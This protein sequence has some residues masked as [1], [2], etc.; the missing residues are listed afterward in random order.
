MLVQNYSLVHNAVLAPTLTNQVL[1]G[2]NHFN[3][4][5]SD[6]NGSFNPVALGFI[7]ALTVSPTAPSPAIRFTVRGTRR[8]ICPCSR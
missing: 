6:A 4:S 5:F 2:V 1:V 7:P 3:Q 8:S